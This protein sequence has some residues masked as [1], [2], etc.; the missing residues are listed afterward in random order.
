MTSHMHTSQQENDRL[1]EDFEIELSDLMHVVDA[2]TE[3]YN[4]PL[5]VDR[6]VQLEKEDLFEW[7]RDYLWL[8]QLLEQSENMPPSEHTPLT[9]SVIEIDC[10]I[11]SLQC[12]SDAIERI[13]PEDTVARLR[14]SYSPTNYV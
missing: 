7:R 14:H 4:D 9:S 5:M 6:T 10:I 13:G 2:I 3:G 8:S 12:I 1:V 11:S